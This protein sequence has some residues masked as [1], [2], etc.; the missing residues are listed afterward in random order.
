MPPLGQ[1]PSPRYD[2]VPSKTPTNHSRVYTTQ[3][4]LL[5]LPQA[6]PAP[7]RPRPQIYRRMCRMKR[8]LSSATA[9]NTAMN[10]AT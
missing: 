10:T 9:W 3:D 7:Y 6:Q 4:T 8:T 2:A 1:P 5:L